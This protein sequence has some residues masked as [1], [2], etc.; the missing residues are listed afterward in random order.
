M[1]GVRLPG[2]TTY[3]LGEPEPG[4]GRTG[5]VTCGYG[6][7]PATATAGA[8]DP[9]LEVTVATYVDAASASDRLAVA[10]DAGQAAGARGRDRRRR[11]GP[12]RCW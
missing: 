3:L 10:G 9:L 6:V 2:T 7:T 12:T 8:S 1:L 11:R 5:R 4:V